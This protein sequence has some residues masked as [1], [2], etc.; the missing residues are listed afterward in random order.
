MAIE[1]ERKFLLKNNHWKQIGKGVEY[2]QGYLNSD[3]HRT[4]RVRTVGDKGYLTIKGLSRGSLRNEYEYEIPLDDALE[5]LELCEQPLI[6]KKRYRIKVEGLTW[7]IDEFY[8]KNEGLCLAEVELETEDQQISLPDWI[9]DEV[10]NDPR[11]FNS[12]LMNNPYSS[13]KEGA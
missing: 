6:R 4:V 9:G 1:I 7:E 10:T 12:N 8:G 2:C 3:K 11:Y 13:W 5:L